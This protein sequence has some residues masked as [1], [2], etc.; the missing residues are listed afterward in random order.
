MKGEIFIEYL[1]H[2]R[3]E[4]PNRER[5]I[6]LICDVHA[7]HRTADVKK[8]AAELH[9]ILLFIPPG[10]TDCLQPLDRR[11]FG[12]LKSEARRLFRRRISNNI[13]IKRSKREAVEDMITT[14]ERLSDEV[15]KAAWDIYETEEEWEQEFQTKNIASRLL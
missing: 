10:A 12:A 11:V 6:H 9:I 14:W 3:N 4:I 7:S 15:L 5:T 8:T 13:E 2:L 1:K